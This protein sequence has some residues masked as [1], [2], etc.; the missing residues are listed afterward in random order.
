MEYLDK[1]I[2]YAVK[3][4]FDWNKLKSIKISGKVTDWQ[5][6][7]KGI[8]TIYTTDGITELHPNDILYDHKF[9]EFLYGYKWLYHLQMQVIADNRFQYIINF[10]K[11]KGVTF[12]E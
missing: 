9:A 10:L 8:I 11:K 12:N 2:D 7:F 5:S 3:Q 1:T 6:D 4:G